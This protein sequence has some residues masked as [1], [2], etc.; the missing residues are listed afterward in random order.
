MKHSLIYK[1]QAWKYFSRWVLLK[2]SPDGEIV[3]CYTSGKWMPLNSKDSQAG[4]L[5]KTSD[6][7]ACFFEEDNVRPQSL[8]DNRYNGGRQDIFRNKLENEIGKDRVDRLYIKSRNSSKIGKYELEI[9]AKIYKEKLD[10]EI[11]LKGNPWK[12]EK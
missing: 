9:L 3:Q 2:H 1:H 5:I 10:Q 8:Q 4:H 7:I 6:S 11:K 12:H